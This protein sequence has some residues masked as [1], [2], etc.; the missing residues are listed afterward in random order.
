MQNTNTIIAIP[1]LCPTHKMLQKMPRRLRDSHEQSYRT[2][3]SGA[4]SVHL[5]APEPAA[6]VRVEVGGKAKPED[7]Y[8]KPILAELR[9]RGAVT[10][11]TKLVVTTS[12]EHRKI[13]IS[14]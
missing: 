2:V 11:A 6:T 4:L 10:D 13:I 1:L 7:Y 14:L 9:K 5:T 8:V 12:T 3:V